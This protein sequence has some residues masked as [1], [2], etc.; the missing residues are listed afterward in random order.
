MPILALSFSLLV[1]DF[2]D[3]QPLKHLLGSSACLLHVG[4]SGTAE[5]TLIPSWLHW[6][7]CTWQTTNRV[8]PMPI[9]AL[10]DQGQALSVHPC[11]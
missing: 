2:M 9:K 10:H 8:S 6:L 7:P 4:K 3:G 11:A 1:A 5:L